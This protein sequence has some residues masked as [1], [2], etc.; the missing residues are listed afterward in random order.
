[1]HPSAG[2]SAAPWRSFWEL[3]A[4]CSF[5]SSSAASAIGSSSSSSSSHQALLPST[6]FSFNAIISCFA[7]ATDWECVRYATLGY[8][9]L[10]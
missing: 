2:S 5:F 1:M 7:S 10:R 8:A 9:A 6:R 4:N 3:Q